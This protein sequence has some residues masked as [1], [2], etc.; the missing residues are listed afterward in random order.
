MF[1]LSS[2]NII[3]FF[4]KGFFRWR[5]ENIPKREFRNIYRENGELPWY[6]IDENGN[7]RKLK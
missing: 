1:C 7:E 6:Y 4:Y 5:N 2:P 3:Y